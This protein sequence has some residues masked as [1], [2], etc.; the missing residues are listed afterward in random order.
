MRIHYSFDDSAARLPLAIR[1]TEGVFDRA[2][3]LRNA[4]GVQLV[5]LTTQH[6]LNTGTTL[7]DELVHYFDTGTPSEADP[8]ALNACY[9]QRDL[10][11]D[12][13][14]DLRDR[15]PSLVAFD[16]IEA[17]FPASFERD[18]NLALA[19]TV[20]GVPAFGYVR[21]FSDSEGEEFHGMVVNLAQAY[22]HLESELGQFSLSLLADTIRSG[23]F[24]HE[25]FQLAYGEYRESLG[26]PSNAPVDLLKDALL[27]RGI[28]WY[29][30][31]RHDLTFYDEALG[32]NG[33]SL[34]KCVV[35]WN[36]MM[37]AARDHTISDTR[38][39]EW[40]RPRD[41][42]HPGELEVDVVGYYAARA[43]G[44]Q[45]GIDGLREAVAQGPDRFIALYNALGPHTLK[46]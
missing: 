42:R 13:L 20:V 37:D 35:S 36:E 9:V 14:R 26:R 7:V 16:E 5:E 29:L 15:L 17:L 41:V 32:L 2:A 44:E 8:Y 3:D 30:S 23:F 45:H 33:D 10:L 1:S 34:P 6:M 4:P 12:L 24:N 11:D 38:L 22:P 18:L 28:A 31:Y 25:G 21:S 27:S 40:L 39:D 46:S 19:F 43:I